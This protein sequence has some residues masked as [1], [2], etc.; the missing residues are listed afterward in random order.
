MCSGNDIDPTCIE[1]LAEALACNSA[2][3][4]LNVTIA[5]PNITGPRT[6]GSRSR[7]GPTIYE[8]LSGM[9]RVNFTPRI[10][11]GVGVD[12]LQA[13]LRRDYRV[14]HVRAVVRTRVM[15]Q[16]GRCRA[17]GASGNRSKIMAWLCERAPLWVVVHVCALLRDAM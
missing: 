17:A 7:D 8:A 16:T 5:K 14:P 10:F 11:R 15:C 4:S 13:E 12:F 3:T 2:L 1:S 9:F 6:H